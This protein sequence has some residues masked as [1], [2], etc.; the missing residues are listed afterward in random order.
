MEQ[1]YK[2]TGIL[3]KIL[4][5]MLI[6]MYVVMCL[7]GASV[8]ATDTEEVTFD[9]ST[10]SLVYQS[11]SYPI[12][13]GFFEY[14]YYCFL[15]DSQYS[16]VYICVSDEPFY[17]AH[18]SSSNSNLYYF[19]H[20]GTFKYKRNQFSNLGSVGY[21]SFDLTESGSGSATGFIFDISNTKSLYASF[22]IKDEAD[23]VLFPGASQGVLAGVTIPEIQ[24]KVRSAKESSG[25]GRSAS[26]T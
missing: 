14:K 6:A 24:C 10:H 7:F 15:S 23:N 20:D 22:D 1:V 16:S 2:K 13:D 11:K 12:A 18:A 21:C 4:P 3:F 9:V 25:V 5:C 8:F 17:L 19:K 26:N